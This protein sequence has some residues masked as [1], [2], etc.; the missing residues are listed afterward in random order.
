MAKKTVFGRL[1]PTRKKNISN[2][3]RVWRKRLE[4]KRKRKQNEVPTGP[5]RNQG[6]HRGIPNKGTEKNRLD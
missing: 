5:G 2:R 1:R 6:H 4:K 3:R